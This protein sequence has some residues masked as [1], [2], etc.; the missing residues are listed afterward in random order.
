MTVSHHSCSRDEFL[1]KMEESLNGTLVIGGE[2]I[3]FMV[4][5]GDDKQIYLV[6]DLRQ[7]STFEVVV[8][9]CDAKDVMTYRAG[10][11]GQ[12]SFP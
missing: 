10:R 8:F 3:Y 2:D 5:E 4:Q 11:P 12:M 7:C 9:L 1:K 6:P